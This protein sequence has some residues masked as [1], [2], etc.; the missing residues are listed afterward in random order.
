MLITYREYPY[1]VLSYFS[2]DYNDHTF[3]SEISYE[4][5]N[6]MLN[7]KIDLELTSETLKELIN[8]NKAIFVASYRM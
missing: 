6:G 8:E 7:L 5:E 1:P 4:V 3:K 2:D